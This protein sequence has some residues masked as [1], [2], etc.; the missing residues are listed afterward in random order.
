ML[1]LGAVANLTQFRHDD[2]TGAVTVVRTILG[3]T[4]VYEKP[5][6]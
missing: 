3:G 6:T 4:V 2:A 5:G 1:R